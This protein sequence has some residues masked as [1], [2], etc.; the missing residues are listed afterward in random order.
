VIARTAQA[1]ITAGISAVLLAGLLSVPARAQTRVG[2]EVPFSAASPHPYPSG[3]GTAPAWSVQVRHPGATYLAI[4]FDRFELGRGDRVVVRSAGGGQRHV[5]TE[6]G[7]HGLQSFWATHIKGDTAVVELFRRGRHET[8]WGLSIDKYAAGMA[9]LGLESG[10]GTEAICGAD[11]RS[12]AVCYQASE[13]EAYNLSR[14][15]ARLLVNGQLL[16]TGWLVGCEGHLITNNH[17]IDDPDLLVSPTEAVLNTDYEFLAEAPTCG[18]PNGPLQWPGPIWTGTPTLVQRD[19]FLDYAYIHLAGNPQDVY[20][21]FQ[22]ANRAPVADERIFIPQHPGGQAKKLGL[23][24]SHPTDE[25][26]FCEVAQPDSGE[27]CINGSSVGETTYLCDTQQGS[28]GSPV[29]GYSS[30]SVIALHHCGLCPNLGVP[31]TALILELGAHL[32]SCAL[33]DPVTELTHHGHS[34]D[35]SDFGN[36]NGVAEPVEILTLAVDLRNDG[37][38][39]ATNVSAV[40]S[41]TTPGITI[42]DDTAGWPQIPGFGSR[43]SVWPHFKVEVDRSV[44]CGTVMEFDLA[45][46][47]D[48][49]AFSASFDEIIGEH[50]GSSGSW[51][52]L[53]T[54]LGIPDKDPEGS[55]STISVSDSFPLGHVTASVEIT[56]TKINHLEIDLISPEGTVVRLHNGSGGNGQDII[57]TYDTLTQPDGP[58]SMDDFLGEN[59]NGTWQLEVVDKRTNETGTLQS[60]S[61]D[62]AES[63]TIVCDPVP[64]RVTAAADATPA[65]VCD[66]DSLVLADAGSFAHGED[67]SGA[68]EYRFKLFTA[69]LQDSGIRAAWPRTWPWS[70]SP[71]LPPRRRRPTRTPT[72]CAWRS[73]GWISTPVP[74]SPPTPG[75]MTAG[76]WWAPPGWSHWTPR[77]AAGPTRWRWET[78]ADAPAP[79]AWRCDARRARRRR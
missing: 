69:V 73:P 47:S 51:P 12:N 35:D 53:D 8:A 34:V 30:Q 66:G 39:L 14:A 54:P 33:S 20:G 24:S 26:G 41:T 7:R 15:V 22:M 23:Q 25:S 40:L 70:R 16:C 31:S 52:S 59:V 61:L 4:H 44:A 17:C 58:G 71:W 5:F 74:A 43:T 77:G 19:F 3:T 9:D 45:I 62:A 60:W 1:G 42:H 72:P 11:D 18:S 38:L 76:R 32:P 67:C 21:S 28:S 10:S 75:A 37:N 79:P 78:P 46:Q 29:V 49:G 50:P 63:A 56:H 68:L 6:H 13:P 64:C 55:V 48:Q 2:Y 27:V 57:T 36:R 65:S